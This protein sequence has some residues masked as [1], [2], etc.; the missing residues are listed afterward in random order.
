MNKN[1]TKLRRKYFS[2]LNTD[3]FDDIREMGPN[4]MGTSEG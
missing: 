1:L 2:Y 4:K 3:S